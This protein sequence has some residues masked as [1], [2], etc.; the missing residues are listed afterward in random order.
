LPLETKKAVLWRLAEKHYSRWQN[1]SLPITED[2]WGVECAKT[3]FGFEAAEV[4]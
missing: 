2:G 4:D 3:A 1:A